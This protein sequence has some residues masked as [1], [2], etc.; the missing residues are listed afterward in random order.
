MRGG[1]PFSREHQAI[2]QSLE[3]LRLISDRLQRQE[4][5][6]TVDL[7]LVLK[8]LRDVGQ[9]CLENTEQLLL[10]PILARA[11]ANAAVSPLN[12]TIQRHL[13]VHSLFDQMTQALSS[14]TVGEFGLLSEHYTQLLTDLIFEEDHVLAPLLASLLADNAGIEDLQRFEESERE[15]SRLALEQMLAIRRLEAKYVNPHCI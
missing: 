3:V 4:F 9:R 5:V 13:L 12:A 15:V 14:A 10:R 6:D 8:F 2:L 7:Q 1:A 11:G